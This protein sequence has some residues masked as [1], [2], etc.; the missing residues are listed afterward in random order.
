VVGGIGHLAEGGEVAESHY[1]TDGSEEAD[2]EGGNDSGFAPGIL[3]LQA[4]QFGDGEEEDDEVEEDVE[5]AVDVDCGL[6][7]WTMALVLAVPS[8]P[9]VALTM[10]SL[11]GCTLGALHT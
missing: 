7:D 6:G 5:G 4:D 1:T 9:E 3:D 10:V 2:E 11:V 8:V